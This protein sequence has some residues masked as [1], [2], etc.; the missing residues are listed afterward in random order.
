MREILFRGK[1]VDT[2]EWV[3]GGYSLYPHGRFPCK[4]T[5]YDV[6]DR[7]IWRPV[8]VVPA[9]VGQYTGLKDKN[10]KRIFEGDIVKAV[11]R[12]YI[13]SMFHGGVVFKRGCYGI[14]YHT[15]PHIWEFKSFHRIG[16]IGHWQDMGAS[17]TVTYTYEVIGNIHDHPE[18]LEVRHE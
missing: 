6:A 16:E 13:G 17:G 14:E 1:D 3:F 4:P 11:S 5:I 18:K 7:G 10:G 8:E 15:L 2:Q 9:T 12:D